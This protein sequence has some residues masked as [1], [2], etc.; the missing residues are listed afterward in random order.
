VNVCVVRVRKEFAMTWFCEQ[1]AIS[2]FVRDV[3]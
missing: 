2:W 1:F 3:V